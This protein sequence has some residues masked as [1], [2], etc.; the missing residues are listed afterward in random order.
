MYAYTLGL[1]WDEYQYRYYIVIYSLVLTSALPKALAIP[2][3]RPIC[4]GVSVNGREG[5]VVVV[6]QECT[7]EVAVQQ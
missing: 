4:N 6:V 2:S 3:K 5:V 7:E 1:C